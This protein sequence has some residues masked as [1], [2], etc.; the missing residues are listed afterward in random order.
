MQAF[1]T[2]VRRHGVLHVSNHCDTIGCDT[3][4]SQPNQVS[5]PAMGE[6]EARVHLPDTPQDEVTDLVCLSPE[7]PAQRNGFA[8]PVATI[9]YTSEQ[10]YC[11][12]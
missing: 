9:R 7:P 3:G 1:G 4:S 11:G 10:R 2:K 12:M 8:P 6:G 5:Q